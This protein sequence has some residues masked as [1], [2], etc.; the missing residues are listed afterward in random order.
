MAPTSMVQEVAVGWDRAT[1]QVGS[2]KL[3]SLGHFLFT[4][5]DTYTVGCII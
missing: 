4:C 5:L 1:V 2:C 3:C